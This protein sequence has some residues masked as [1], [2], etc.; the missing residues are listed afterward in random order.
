MKSEK[1]IASTEA[2]N[3][4][5]NV[6]FPLSFLYMNRFQM[7]VYVKSHLGAEAVQLHIPTHRLI[8]YPAALLLLLL[9]L[10][11]FLPYKAIPKLTLADQRLRRLLYSLYQ[12]TEVIQDIHICLFEAMLEK[13]IEYI[14]Q[15]LRSL[16]QGL[17][18]AKFLN[19]KTVSL[20]I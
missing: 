19:R 3:K 2:G 6:A 8:I 20:Q 15:F 9:L 13:K 12:R 11:A 4:I 17:L 14:I 16:E 18:R 7:G 10:A 5:V 1:K